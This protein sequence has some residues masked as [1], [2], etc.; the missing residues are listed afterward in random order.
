VANKNLHAA[1]FRATIGQSAIRNAKTRL[2]EA[3]LQLRIN[4]SLLADEGEA[5]EAEFAL[6]QAA[7][8]VA[9]GIAILTSLQQ[10]A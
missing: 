10:R 1:V 9:K 2:E 4:H 3:R 7:A 6:S 8:W 5:M